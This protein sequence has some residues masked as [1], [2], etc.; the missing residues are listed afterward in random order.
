MGVSSG[1]SGTESVGAGVKDSSGAGLE[2]VAGGVCPRGGGG[3]TA[4]GAGVG[5]ISL[6]LGVVEA[7]GGVSGCSGGTGVWDSSNATTTT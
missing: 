2:W 1:R 6:G 4:F 3:G 7:T 5:G